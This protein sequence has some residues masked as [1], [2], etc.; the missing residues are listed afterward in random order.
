MMHPLGHGAVDDIGESEGLHVALHAGGRLVDGR[1][2]RGIRDAAVEA[3][4]DPLGLA[5]GASLFGH[6][7][8]D[9]A[10]R[11]PQDHPTGAVRREPGGVLGAGLHQQDGLSYVH[12][13]DHSIVAIGQHVGMDGGRTRGVMDHRR[14][15]VVR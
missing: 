15:E 8:V 12:R 14:V 9:L 6:A 3:G 1:Q 10:V 7:F 11:G 2:F 13:N 5:S 4:V